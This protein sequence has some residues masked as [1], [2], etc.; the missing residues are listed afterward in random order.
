[1]VSQTMRIQPA[2]LDDRTYG[3]ALRQLL[4]RRAIDGQ[5]GSRGAD[6]LHASRWHY[7]TCHAAVHATYVYHGAC[8]DS[9]TEL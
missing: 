3:V 4:Q 9:A 8:E 7:G 6:T 2:I 1:M 5:T